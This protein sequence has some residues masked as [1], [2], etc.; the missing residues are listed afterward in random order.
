M[1]VTSQVACTALYWKLVYEIDGIDC[2]FEGT[3]LLNKQELIRPVNIDWRL[4]PLQEA[5]IAPV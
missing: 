1:V 4:G 3:A 2:W 5:L